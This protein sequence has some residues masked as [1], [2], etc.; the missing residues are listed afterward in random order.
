M[1]TGETEEGELQEAVQQLET[2]LERDRRHESGIETLPRREGGV[3]WRALLC[4]LTVGFA[5]AFVAGRAANRPPQEETPPPTPEATAPAQTVSAATVEATR[6]E[7][8]LEVTGTVRP[9]D[10]LPILPQAN[11][12]QIVEVRVD[13]GDYVEA[14]QI[15]AVLDDAVLQTQIDRAQSQISSANSS[16]AQAEAGIAQAQ[17]ARLEAEAGVS[18]A[19]AGVEQAQAGVAQAEAGVE[20]AQAAT[21]R[22]RTGIV[23]AEAELARAQARQDQAEREYQRYQNLARSGA[24]SQQEAEVRQTDV[25]TAREDVRVAQANITAAR[26][27]V[28]NAQANE[29]NAQA[30]LANAQ[31]NVENAQ[32]NVSSARARLES[33]DANVLASTASTESAQAG[34]LGEQAN[35]SQLETQLEQT[36]VRAPESG[37][38][39]ERFAQV[40]DVTGASQLFS[41]IRNGVLELDAEVPETLLP[42]VRA[43]MAAR[44]TSDADDRLNL[45]GSVRE[46]APII[47]EAT[48]EAIVEIDLPASDL[49]RPGMFLNAIVATDTAPG[50]TVPAQAVLPQPDGSKIAYKLTEDNIAIA[51]TVTVGE[52]IGDD[53]Q[54]LTD[55]RIEIIA[56]LTEGDWI[57]VSGAGYLKDGDR[58]T[59]SD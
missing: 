6:V 58:V 39:A 9:R 22:A 35:V 15:L 28:S 34:V 56:G 42:Q 25:K 4:G 59:V 36:L 29:A 37:I 27:E 49:L 40:G 20:Q 31:A 47:D 13:E 52:I 3:P 16:V 38:I 19:Q 46:I 55:A 10:M 43:G 11:G 17:A 1:A 54:D 14:G 12:L 33:A 21:A 45:R 57:V 7:R 44:I 51:Q 32:A 18:Q 53:T 24:V 30:T 5:L 50:L 41:I 23:Q 26:T 8:T 2:Q 48:R